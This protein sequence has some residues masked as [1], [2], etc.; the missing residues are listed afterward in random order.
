MFFAVFPFSKK[1]PLNLGRSKAL[2][3]TL[4]WFRFNLAGAGRN[5]WCPDGSWMVRIDDYSMWFTNVND[6]VIERLLDSF[7]MIIHVYLYNMFLLLLYLLGC[8]SC[9]IHLHTYIKL[10]LYTIIY[11]WHMDPC[12]GHII[13]REYWMWIKSN[14]STPF[15][16]E[17]GSSGC[18]GPLFLKPV[19][20]GPF[21]SKWGYNQYR[22]GLCELV[23]SSI[24]F[25]VESY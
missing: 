15:G 17:H 10:Y 7:R 25:D 21:W 14:R 18:A 9:H 11:I 19:I 20:G 2:S 6:F 5:F 8:I 16:V 23:T 24:F 13:F 3:W 22:T 4:A 12:L 1:Q